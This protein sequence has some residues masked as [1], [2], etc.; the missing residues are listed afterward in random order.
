M[1]G[2]LVDAG[3]GA[4]TASGADPDDYGEVD[5]ETGLP[6]RRAGPANPFLPPSGFFNRGAAFEGSTL[7]SDVAGAA[8]E[9]L[10]QRLRARLGRWHELAPVLRLLASR[11][12]T[13]EMVEAEA[14]LDRVEQNEWIVSFEVRESMLP[15]LEA[16]AN[17]DADG[18]QFGPAAAAA[19]LAWLDRPS[20]PA[21]I[22]E[23]RYLDVPLRA[24]TA[25]YMAREDLGV[26][27]CLR[28]ARAVKEKERGRAGHWWFTT[29]PGDCL[30]FKHWR[31]AQETKTADEARRLSRLALSEAVSADARLAVAELGWLEEE[32]IAEAEA[33]ARRRAEGGD[34]GD[35]T[36]DALMATTAPSDSELASEAA[37]A[38]AREAAAERARSRA[39]KALGGA[40]AIAARR[41]RAARGGAPAFARLEQSEHSW[42]AVPLC[43]FPWT[44]VGDDATIRGVAAR[45]GRASS[46]GE[47]QS[48]A[49]RA[50]AEAA[51]AVADAPPLTAAAVAA[52]PRA[53][54]RGSAFE[55]SFGA[56]RVPKSQFYTAVLPRWRALESVVDPVGIEVYDAAS[57][58][59]LLWGGMSASG[60]GEPTGE[61]G[62][63]RALDERRRLRR[64]PCLMVIDRAATD[65]EAAVR[66]AEASAQRT[67][68]NVRRGVAAGSA[69]GVGGEA[70]AVGAVENDPPGHFVVEVKSSSGAAGMDGGTKLDLLSTGA[71]AEGLESGLVTRV[72]GRLAICVRAPRPEFVDPNEGGDNPF[73]FSDM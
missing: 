20:A 43:P 40:D 3:G 15:A 30:A 19:A 32:E 29:H 53:D 1:S 35:R 2:V 67:G 57:V 22:L 65:V 54:E 5:P 69:D 18:W 60:L 23:M 58:P 56:F 52:P 26:D 8:D 55:R 48:A 12:I 9:R 28:L 13:N 70:P 61:R 33:A 10:L 71:A 59:A 39:E 45:S 46:G 42:R 38:A 27:A 17:P 36:G 6:A 11:G 47:G 62:A 68:A 16:G 51:R 25:C 21:S 14:G 72:V 66:E 34:D 37:A 63:Q 7:A 44:T 50:D 31:D 4:L 24:P 73:N 49:E 64:G 41:L